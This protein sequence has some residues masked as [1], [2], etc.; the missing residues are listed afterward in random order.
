MN[1]KAVV[2]TIAI[3]L[4]VTATGCTVVNPGDFA[5]KSTLGTVKQETLTPGVHTA[6][7]GFDQVTIYSGQLITAPEEFSSLTSDGQKIIV[8]ATVQYTVNSQ[9]AAQIL[10]TVGSDN[11]AIRNKIVQPVLLSSMKDV[12]SRNTMFGIIENQQKIATEVDALIQKNLQGHGND[13][14]TIHGLSVT[15]FILDPQVQQAIEKKQIAQQELA[16]KTTEVQIAGKEAE[17]LKALQ[18]AI[19]P[20]TLMKEAIEKWDGH[21][22]PPTLGS[23]SGINLLVQPEQ[24]K[25]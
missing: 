19:T 1:S 10:Q 9:K 7:P 13:L 12:I 24:P 6:I 11:D 18:G 16:A 25:K 21:G 3:V 23:G 5:V 22:I 20:Q 15:G 2:L 14:V 4:A 17:R 8:H